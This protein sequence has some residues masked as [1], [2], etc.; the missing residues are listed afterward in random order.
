MKN[1]VYSFSSDHIEFFENLIAKEDKAVYLILKEL[2]G[3]LEEN[4]QLNILQYRGLL[5]LMADKSEAFEQTLRILLS[6]SNL[7]SINIIYF[8]FLLQEGLLAKIRTLTSNIT[9]ERDRW[10]I[11]SIY[12]IINQVLAKV[13][14]DSEKYIVI[15]DSRQDT[16][17]VVHDNNVLFAPFN[18][19][20]IYKIQMHEDEAMHYIFNLDK[21]DDYK[22]RLRDIWIQN[23]N[24]RDYFF[25]IFINIFLEEIKSSD[26]KLYDYD[27]ASDVLRNFF[28]VYYENNDS[29]KINEIYQFCIMNIA[30]LHYDKY[31]ERLFAEDHNIQHILINCLLYKPEQYFKSLT[32][33]Y[34]K[35]SYYKAW[36]YGYSCDG[37]EMMGGGMS[38]SGSQFSIEDVPIVEK[39]FIPFFEDYYKDN[40]HKPKELLFIRDIILSDFSI[41]AENPLCLKRAIL[42]VLVKGL[43]KTAGR[44]R[45]QYIEWLLKILNLRK[46]I[47][48]C[49]EMIFSYLVKYQA[50]ITTKNYKNILRLIEEDIKNSY[51][52]TPS[53]VFSVKIILF[54]VRR[55]V[56]EAKEIMLRLVN[57]PFYVKYDRWN[58]YTLSNL[59]DFSKYDPLFILE[60]IKCLILS[61]KGIEDK[62]GWQ[63]EV[64]IND[65]K[66][67]LVNIYLSGQ[68]NEKSI[69]NL[70]TP[71]ID[72]PDKS[73]FDEKLLNT[74]VSGVSE[75]APEKAYELVFTML[76]KHKPHK[77]FKSYRDG[78]V[79]VADKLA[80][81]AIAIKDDNVE[82]NKILDKAIHL[83]ELFLH[84]PDP[85]LE[86][87]YGLQYNENVKSNIDEGIITT[88]RGRLC[89]AIQQLT[90][91]EYS[92][93]KSWELTKYLLS[94]ENLYVVKNA[95]VPFI[96]V[97]KRRIIWMPPNTQNDV[98]SF[99]M[100][101]LEKF[102][103]YK[104][105]A[106]I[107]LHVFSVFR[108]IDEE[109]AIKLIETIK[110][111][112]SS[113]FYIYY[114]FFREDHFK[115]KPAFS[116]EWFRNR[117]KQVIE[118]PPGNDLVKQIF[119]QF[120][121]L[122]E[123]NIAYIEKIASYILSYQNDSRH[124]ERVINNINRIVDMILKKDEARNYMHTAITIYKYSLELEENYVANLS[125]YDNLK[126]KRHYMDYY[127]ESVLKILYI[128]SKPDFY[129]AVD[130]II[131]VASTSDRA[132]IDYQQLVSIFK[133]EDDNTY[134]GPALVIIQ[135]LAEIRPE[136]YNV[137]YD[138]E[139]KL[140][141]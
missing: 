136:Y 113:F 133:N 16:L 11:N 86:D 71:Y 110:D 19:G 126:E 93:Q 23:F 75:I 30:F 102:G 55:N 141:K 128:I 34:K 18:N 100:Y 5:D 17:E 8:V 4:K 27:T 94:D 40:Y 77:V 101:S 41:N 65:V 22:I 45:E 14:N 49:S 24:C 20:K 109:S 97:M 116:G 57:N 124:D 96:E 73:E 82:Q 2:K 42:P 104:P 29:L 92:F 59:E 46:G 108:S 50:D 91:A 107:L 63:F 119:W 81:K 89:W 127:H 123:E 21:P 90:L 95:M 78:L 137:M 53:S 103:K 54:L 68:D 3:A 130:K 67:Y 79:D 125:K 69:I 58:F 99:A 37:T 48:S 52:G 10:F 51:H 140:G 135:K 7:N 98:E 31:S 66:P 15:D 61:K 64:N 120:G 38:I 139:S 13:K 115:D 134:I 26:K 121:K 112:E 117:L 132:Y 47:P 36:E 122:I 114:S 60:L 62:E 131:N 87:K 70:L 105:I 25:R 1:N 39:I 138:L 83:I 84:D 74:F 72:N 129:S 111:E 12:R 44:Y 85:S 32:S 80:K 6:D 56:K 106:K 43:L 28:D 33:E 35:I 76:G 118:N 9:K 88:V